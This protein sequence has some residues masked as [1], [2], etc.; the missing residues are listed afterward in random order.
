MPETKELHDQVLTEWTEVKATIE[1]LQDRVPEP[2]ELSEIKELLERYGER[3]DQLE[4]KDK[5]LRQ[6]MEATRDPDDLPPEAKAHGEAYERYLKR[7]MVRGGDLRFRPTDEMGGKGVIAVPRYGV[8]D[9]RN[10]L[11]FEYR[12]LEVDSEEY[13]GLSVDSDPAGGFLVSPTMSTNVIRRVF[14]TSPVRQYASVLT[15]SSDAWEEPVD[16][17]EAD[18][19]WV[20]ERS[21]RPETDTPDVDKLRIPLEEVYA[22]PR[23]TQ[24]MLDMIASVEDWLTGKVADKITRKENTAFVSGNGV[25]KPMGLTQYVSTS[26]AW[27]TIKSVN[28]G[29]ASALTYDGIIDVRADLQSQYLPRSNWYMNRSTRGAARKLVDGNG[30]PLWG[31]GLQAGD[32]D[33]LDGRPVVIFEDLADVGADAYPILFGDLM[34]GY[35]VIDHTQGLRVLRD[36]FTA[37]PEIIFYTTKY[38]GGGIRQGR[39][40]RFQKVSA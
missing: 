2:G 10:V 39:A 32:P 40:L 29:N 28:S 13:K 24:K 25:K 19:G 18:A 9:G 20:G 37:K 21:S 6:E 12:T 36:P 26:A 31:P 7:P 15:I 17:D 34:T 35:Y 33:T 30:N 11:S 3:F 16:D 8:K 4:A 1:T 14:D 38:V 23:S 22:A 27:N 5:R